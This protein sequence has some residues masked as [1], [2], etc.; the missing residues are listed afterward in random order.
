MLIA[1][2][3]GPPSRPGEAAEFDDHIVGLDVDR[4]LTPPAMMS[5]A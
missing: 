4:R 3:P 1:A 5:A 2:V